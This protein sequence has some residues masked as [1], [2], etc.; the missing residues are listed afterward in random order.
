LTPADFAPVGTPVL[1][2]ARWG[3]LDLGGEVN[4]FDLDFISPVTTPCVD[5]A[6]LTLQGD[7]HV[8]RGGNYISSAIWLAVPMIYDDF[9]G[10]DRNPG[11]GFRCARS[12]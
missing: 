11:N 3:H 7:W 4:E 9:G 5:C 10:A 1:G 12:P 6:N 8:S 2:M